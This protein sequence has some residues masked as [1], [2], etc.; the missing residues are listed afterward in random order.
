MPIA[1]IVAA[2]QAKAG[3]LAGV[4]GAPTE[5]PE[6]INQFPFAIAYPG[7]LTADPMSDGWRRGLGT[8]ICELHCARVLLPTAVAQAVPLGDAF[9]NAILSDLTLGGAVDT[10]NEL[11]GVF[12]FLRY[13][14]AAD[15]HI[16]WRFEI[17]Y[18]R[19]DLNT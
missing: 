15:A 18:K 19:E 3:A 17:D 16:G 10:V 4:K 8:V 12:G 11:R 13:G 6:S 5:P 9:V 14:S 2:V 1:S 7:S